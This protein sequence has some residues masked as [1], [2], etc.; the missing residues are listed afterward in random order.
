MPL[1]RAI[2]FLAALAAAAPT[3]KPVSFKTPDGWTIA[4][5]YRP[6]RAGR[7]T[8]ILAHGVG[9]ASQEWGRLAERLTLEGV[10]TLAID[11]RGHA[12]SQNGPS[13]KTGFTSFDASG[14][15][16]RAAADLR[17]AAAW[18]KARGVPEERIA[19]GGA[20]IGANLASVV[21][22]QS[23]SAP[24]LLLLSPGADY[25]SARLAARP[26]LKTLAAA[27]TPDGY[28]YAA[29]RELEQRG[30]ATALIAP[31]GHGVQMFD[32]PATL[33]A[34][35]SWVSKRARN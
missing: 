1:G 4:A 16:P 6:A 29:V 31:S 7:A 27:S 33:D 20:S 25:R 8:L 14:E 3:P 34:I 11:L 30:L 19:F 22:A 13:G 17:A 15:W 23:P 5:T 2:L 12:N 18:L 21:A 26:G 28:A 24:F 35:A 9:S 10:G 32:D